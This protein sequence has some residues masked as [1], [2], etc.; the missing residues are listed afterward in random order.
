MTP[1]TSCLWLGG[2]WGERTKRNLLTNEVIR[3][4]KLVSWVHFRSSQERFSLVCHCVS[5]SKI[6]SSVGSSDNPAIITQPLKAVNWVDGF[7]YSQEAEW[8][9][10]V[11]FFIGSTHATVPFCHLFL[12]E[13]QILR[14]NRVLLR[15]QPTYNVGS[16][17]PQ[18]MSA[19]LF[20]SLA[21]PRGDIPCPIALPEVW[22]LFAAPLTVMMV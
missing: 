12:Y 9:S 4:L 16:Q 13:A 1:L 3:Q 21:I 20:A 7:A 17:P 11:A 19:G 6:C 22:C 18:G 8:C 10:K 2:M 14:D 5:G 15:V